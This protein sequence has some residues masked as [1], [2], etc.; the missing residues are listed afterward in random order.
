MF[1]F[2]ACDFT[3]IEN[4]RIRKWRIIKTKEKI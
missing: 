1:I 3:F 4:R 2:Y